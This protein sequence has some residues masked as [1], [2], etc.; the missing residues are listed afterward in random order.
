MV[1][2]IWLTMNFS[3]FAKEPTINGEAYIL[4]NANNGQVLHG[5]NI[6][7]KLNPASTT[8]I[9]TAILALEK[10][11]LGEMVTISKNIPLVQ[12]TKAYLREGETISIE[13]LLNATILHSAND[14]ALAIAE[15]IS[16]SQEKFAALMNNKANEIGVKN[17]HFINPHGLTDEGHLATAYDLALIAQYAMAN[18]GFR[19]LAVK[20]VYDWEGMEWQT[21]MINKNKL[22]WQMENST[23]IKPGYTSL[24][25]HTLVASAKEGDQELIVVILGS[26]ANSLYNDAQKLLEYG[27][28]N[29][30][31][32]VMS[33]PELVVA[34]LMV[35]NN[36]QVD[37]VPVRSA[38]ISIA[39]NQE[40]SMEKVVV[41]DEVKL[42]IKQGD[43]LGQLVISLNGEEIEAIPIKAIGQ[44]KEPYNWLEIIINI[45]AGLFVVQILAKTTRGIIKRRR[46]SRYSSRINSYRY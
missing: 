6:D 13:A 39:S 45:L 26:D 21:R 30:Q 23:G 14:A 10:A 22:L 1:L 19:E 3:F 9:L 34:T 18:Q 24:A 12:G 2:S 7:E 44:A 5:K 11:S 35:A 16:G 46:K 38:S 33:E 42:P 36:Q 37:L 29:F 28:N 25:G 20:K 41:L 31:N 40:V 15:H 4:M 17:S 32:L 8:K 27:F 43:I